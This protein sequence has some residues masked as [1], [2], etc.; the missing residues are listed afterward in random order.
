ALH[1]RVAEAMERAPTVS[2]AEELAEHLIRGGQP[3][4]AL[5]Y[6]LRAGDEAEARYAHGEAE[7]HYQTATALAH[8]VGDQAC[9]MEALEKLAG[10]LITVAR[11]EAALEVLERAVEIARAAGEQED[12][13]RDLAQIGFIYFFR[14]ARAE[15]YARL[16]P[17]V[18]AL[19][20]SP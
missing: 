4:R 7:Q 14:G 11:F 19:R 2:R 17:V 5:P 1:R 13:L 8:D 15:G 18:T 12:M 6:A 20:E 9:E 3:E 10:V 16:E